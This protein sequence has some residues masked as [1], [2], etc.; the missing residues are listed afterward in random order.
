M[1]RLLGFPSGCRNALEL[2][3]GRQHWWCINVT[4]WCMLNGSGLS[5]CSVGFTSG[6]FRIVMQSVDSREK[7]L[8][9]EPV[10]E[11]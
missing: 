6:F 9:R 8:P 1:E 3:K 7:S 2:D 4:G 11:G 10:L 5:L